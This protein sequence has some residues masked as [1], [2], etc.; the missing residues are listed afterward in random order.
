MRPTPW[1]LAEPYRIQPRGYESE[2][3]EDYGAFRIPH[4]KTGV[5]LTV[6]VASGES[7]RADLGAA[8]AWD[9]VSV[10]LPNRPPNWAEMA[11]IKSVFWGDDE[12]VMQLHVP[13]A[14]HKNLHPNCL[15][16]WRP[17]NAPIPRPPGDMVA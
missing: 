10:S 17:L 4:A 15:H 6:M 3:G 9:H 5:T 14:E 12:T 8:Y 11:F 2:P 7:A 1:L 13:T 16:L